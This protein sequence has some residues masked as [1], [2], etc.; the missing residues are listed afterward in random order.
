[1]YKYHTD[2]CWIKRICYENYATFLGI[3][4]RIPGKKCVLTAKGAKEKLK[5]SFVSILAFFYTQ[6]EYN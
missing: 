2:Y 4:Q 3:I 5:Y 1:L 6:R